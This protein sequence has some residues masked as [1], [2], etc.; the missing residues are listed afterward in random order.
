MS[1]LEM[2]NL[3]MS[4]PSKIIS[5]K[6]KK[7]EVISCNYKDLVLKWISLGREY[8]SLTNRQHAK[9]K[10]VTESLKKIGGLIEQTPY[11]IVLIIDRGDVVT[12]GHYPSIDRACSSIDEIKQKYPIFNAVCKTHTQIYNDFDENRI[13]KE[14]CDDLQQ[15][16]D[17]F[18][19]SMLGNIHEKPFYKGI[20]YIS[21]LG[22]KRIDINTKI[23]FLKRELV[24][25]QD[26]YAEITKLKEVYEYNWDLE[27]EETY[28]H[29][30]GFVISTIQEF[31]SELKSNF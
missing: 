15:F 17:T 23:L 9:K 14:I 21:V 4:E 18:D 5:K 25:N 13:T 1:N 11:Y 31:E 3:E 22:K 16:I 10:E 2:S 20:L 7:E 19:S 12:A 30:N 8:L 27:I 29:H 28:T 24:D 26:T 6:K